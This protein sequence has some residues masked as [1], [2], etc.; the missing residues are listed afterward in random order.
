M[1][2]DKEKKK[3]NNSKTTNVPALITKQGLYDVFK[4]CIFIIKSI[5]DVP[6]SSIGP[7][8][9]KMKIC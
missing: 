4:K 1:A 6:F 5:I 9:V 8:H 7:I 3:V 2:Y